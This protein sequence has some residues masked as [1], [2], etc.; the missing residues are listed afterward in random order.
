MVTSLISFP[1]ADARSTLAY[2]SVSTFGARTSN[3]I[4]RP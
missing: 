3:V 2:H 4:W 1:C